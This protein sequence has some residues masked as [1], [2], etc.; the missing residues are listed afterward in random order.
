MVLIQNY[1]GFIWPG[2]LS[3]WCYIQNNVVLHAT[4]LPMRFNKCRLCERGNNAVMWWQSRQHWDG[5]TNIT[6]LESRLA[7]KV[8]NVRFQLSS[9]I[10]HGR[11]VSR[12]SRY[13]VFHRIQAWRRHLVNNR[14]KTAWLSMLER[15]ADARMPSAYEKAISEMHNSECWNEDTSFREYIVWRVVVKLKDKCEWVYFIITDKTI[16]YYN[17]TITMEQ[18]M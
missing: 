6:H 14:N 5:I 12:L 10:S 11:R 16:Y 3:A 7:S 2:H 8:C 17:S 1:A 4:L 13:T 15:I 18:K 9:D